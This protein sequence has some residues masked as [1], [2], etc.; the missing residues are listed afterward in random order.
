MKKILS[1]L[2]LMLLAYNLPAQVKVN[3]SMVNPRKAAGVFI[4][5]VTATVP[6]GQQWRVGPTNIRIAY[7]TIPA[8]S[9]T[10]MEDNPATNVNVNIS[11]NANYWNMTTTKIHN[12]SA[13][14]LNILSKYNANVYHLAPGTYTL[15]S[16]RWNI[17]DSTGCIMSTILPISAVF[18]SMSAMTYTSQWTKTDPTGCVPIGINTQISTIVP[19]DYTLYQNYP[20]P[21]NPSTTIKYDV[22]KK[23]NVKIEIYDAI[24]R[25]IET[26][27]DMELTPGT[28]QVTWDAANYASGLYFYRI[29]TDSYIH[30]NKMV[31]MK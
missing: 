23:S 19:K 27:V 2:I 6:A 5:D 22:P 4:Y 21:F 31:L 11:G 1:V 17:L 29:V 25:E 14:S 24:G 3:F 15:G 18:D 9:L 10:V 20:N 16:V 13:I 28:Y 12:D 26:L 30:T 8:N 7:T